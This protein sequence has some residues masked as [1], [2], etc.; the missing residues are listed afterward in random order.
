MDDLIRRL[1]GGRL[2]EGA[3]RIYVHG[4]KEFEEADRRRQQGIPLGAKVDASLR[5]IAANL[6]LPYNL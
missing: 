2:A 4:E 6:G 3:S 1:K 5:E